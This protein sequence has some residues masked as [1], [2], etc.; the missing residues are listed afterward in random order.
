MLHRLAWALVGATLLA[1]PEQGI[2]GVDP[3][4]EWTVMIYMNGD[5]D[6]ESAMLNDFHELAKLPESKRVSIVVQLDRHDRHWDGDG[7]WTDARRFEIRPGI[8]PEIAQSLPGFEGERD[9][10]DPRVLRDFV[11]WAMAQ[12]PARRYALIISSHGDGWRALNPRGDAARLSQA[13]QHPSDPDP[14]EP[15]RSISSDASSGGRLYNR[16]MQDALEDLL[17]GQRLDLIGFDACLMATLETAY[18]FRRVARVM[19]ASEEAEPSEG[20]AYQVALAGLIVEPSMDGEVLG[21]AIVEAYRSAYPY[22]ETA[23]LSAVRLSEVPTLAT[24]VSELSEALIDLTRSA[25]PSG[26]YKARSDCHAYGEAIHAQT[27][28]ALCVLR[29]LGALGVPDVSPP[30]AAAS[31]ALKGAVLSAHPGDRFFRPKWGSAGLSIYFPRRA[32]DHRGK[33]DYVN[34]LSAERFP[35]EFVDDHRWDEFLAEYT[36]LFP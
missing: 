15:L 5:N 14:E 36:R 25:D 3:A 18:A 13:E 16:A 29:S 6:L 31:E 27:V 1:R 28:D 10:T 20:W 7:D 34:G 12:Y 32:R 2:R 11:T 17:N 19:V 26:L 24:R 8:E 21:R 22:S 9:M 4:R 35:V 30:V 23:T 33:E